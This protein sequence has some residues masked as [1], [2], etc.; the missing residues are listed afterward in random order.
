MIITP[1]NFD[2]AIQ[3]IKQTNPLFVDL[4]TTGLSPYNLS[5]IHI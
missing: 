1:L 5:L 3:H 2:K 4:E